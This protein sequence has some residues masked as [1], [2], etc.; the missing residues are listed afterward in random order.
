MLLENAF[1][2]GDWQVMQVMFIGTA[3]RRQAHGPASGAGWAR[4][5]LGGAADGRRR[6]CEALFWLTLFKVLFRAVFQPLVTGVE[7]RSGRERLVTRRVGPEGAYGGGGPIGKALDGR[8][9]RAQTQYPLQGDMG[10]K[11]V[12]PLSV[13]LEKRCRV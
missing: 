6:M 1:R 5:P 12:K 7:A 9:G 2:E 8:Q 3:T 10:G 4:L 13:S 11:G